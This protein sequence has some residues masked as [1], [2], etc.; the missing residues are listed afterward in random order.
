[1]ISTQVDAPP[2]VAAAGAATVYDALWTLDE[3]GWRRRPLAG[4][5]PTLRADA[6]LAQIRIRGRDTLIVFGGFAPD[7]RRP[8]GGL[9]A[10]D[11][12]SGAWSTL[13]PDDLA[14]KPRAKPVRVAAP[15][16]APPA[17]PGHVR[18]RTCGRI[19]HVL[20]SKFS[21]DEISR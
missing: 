12:A 21:F 20:G 19:L 7:L 3:D 8:L 18:F 13:E 14:P 1:M 16:P 6:S 5:R 9:H 15:A 2:Q 17:P 4:P 11:V 10:L